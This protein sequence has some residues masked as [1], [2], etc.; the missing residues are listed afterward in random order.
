MD[1]WLTDD[2]VDLQNGM[3]SF[4]TGRL[5]L[6]EIAEREESGAVLDRDLWRE[7]GAMGIFS[8]LRDG[9]DMRASVVAFEELGRALVPGPVV[10]TLLAATHLDGAVDGSQIVG[11]LETEQGY[12]IVE[13]SEQIDSALRF[14]GP[15]LCL[16]DR[17]SLAT[18]IL[19][20]PLDALTPVSLVQLPQDV[21]PLAAV[22]GDQAITAYQQGVLLTAALQVGVSAAALD[23]ANSYAKGREQF[24]RPIGSFQAVKHLLAE[25]MTKTEVARAALHAA[26]CALDGASNDQPARPVA[27]A[28]TMA[29][30][31]ALFCGKTGIQVHGGMGFTWEVHAQRYWKRAVVLDNSFGS[32]DY[33]AVAVA[34]TLVT[35]ND[36]KK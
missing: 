23:L 11:H 28:K 15:D 22:S 30:Q 18:E 17:S 36:R 1:F 33:H 29:G 7:L 32:A 3:R 21:P 8:L 9:F 13:H 35:S 26:A 6:D 24:G 25:M 31:A 12:T 34:D 2:Q 27:V 5:P 10:S 19:N 16:I 4:L 14:D 20:R